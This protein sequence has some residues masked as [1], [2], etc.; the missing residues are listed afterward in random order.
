[1]EGTSFFLDLEADTDEDQALCDMYG[2][3]VR[4]Y[5]TKIG[6]W[7]GTFIVAERSEKRGELFDKDVQPVVDEV[8]EI[9]GALLKKNG[10]GYLVG[11]KVS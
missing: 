6:A 9:F 10:S 11:S 4:D 8:G 1:M 5:I 3:Q 2:E 7:G